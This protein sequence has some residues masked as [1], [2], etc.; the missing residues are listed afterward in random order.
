MH[1]AG[2][3]GQG[4]PVTLPVALLYVTVQFRMLDDRCAGLGKGA[5]VDDRNLTGKK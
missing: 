3:L 2:A 4:D 1:E 5:V